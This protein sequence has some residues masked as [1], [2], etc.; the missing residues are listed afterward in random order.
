MIAKFL[1]V[2]GIALILASVFA[3]GG[4]IYRNSTTAAGGSAGIGAFGGLTFLFALLFIFASLAVLIV[5]LVK[6]FREKRLR[7]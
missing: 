2:S 1:I 6:F 7:K 3:I 4:E 5:G